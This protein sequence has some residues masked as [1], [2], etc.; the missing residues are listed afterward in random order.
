MPDCYFIIGT[1]P[2]DVNQVRGD[3][4]ACARAN[5]GRP[6]RFDHDQGQQRARAHVTY[7]TRQEAE[8]ALQPLT[9][10]LESRGNEVLDSGVEG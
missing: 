2:K 4:Q 7:E 3:V 5:G 1:N 10:C 9:E 6:G 8:A